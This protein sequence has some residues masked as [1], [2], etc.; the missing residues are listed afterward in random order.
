M[1]E[2]ERIKMN[3]REEGTVRQRIIDKIGHI[4]S[5]DYDDFESRV[6]QCQDAK[7]TKTGRKG[8]YIGRWVF[9]I[10]IGISTG[11]MGYTASCHLSF[12]S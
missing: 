3:P 11:F 9:T 6:N 5:L 8:L 1:G 12:T 7:V 4:E 10:L 2:D